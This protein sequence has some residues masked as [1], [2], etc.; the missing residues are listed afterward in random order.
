MSFNLASFKK[1]DIS[2][3]LSFVGIIYD[4][5]IK[6]KH[7]KRLIAKLLYWRKKNYTGLIWLKVIRTTLSKDDGQYVRGGYQTS[8]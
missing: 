4:T 2:V 3:V 1:N 7:L 6:K 5:M 8:H